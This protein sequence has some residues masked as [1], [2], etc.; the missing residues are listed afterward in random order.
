[1]LNLTLNRP[2]LIAAG[3]SGGVV[4]DRLLGETHMFCTAKAFA[5]T[6][7]HSERVAQQLGR[8]SPWAH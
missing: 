7:L 3:D 4:A 5:A 8:G 2:I 1:L 6:A